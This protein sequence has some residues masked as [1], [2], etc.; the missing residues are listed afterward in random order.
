MEQENVMQIIQIIQND[1]SQEII[2][3]VVDTLPMSS[4]L[5]RGGASRCSL[6]CF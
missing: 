3:A 6:T 4:P 2:Y 5:I 1:K